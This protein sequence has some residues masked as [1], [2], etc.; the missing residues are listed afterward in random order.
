[1]ITDAGKTY[2]KGFLGGQTATIAQ[3]IALGIADSAPSATDTKMGLEIERDDI[4]LTSYD[5]VSENIVFKAAISPDFIGEIHEVG[6]YAS[7]A[8]AS[9]SDML[10]TSFDSATEDWLTN[11]ADAT[12]VETNTRSGLDSLVQ[13]PPVSTAS[14]STLSDLGIDLST[15]RG[16]DTLTFAYN[17][18]N[19]DAASIEFRFLTD[20]TNYYSFLL[21]ASTLGYHV[22]SFAKATATVTGTPDWAN[23]IEL[24]IITTADASGPAHVSF[25]AVRINSLA[26]N[27]DAVLIAREVLPE[28]FVRQAAKEQQ[29]EFR[30]V[31][32]L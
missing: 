20:A 9:D 3:S 24:D 32:N 14:T 1:M 5:F 26:T 28:P 17:V 6:L 18:G 15:Y 13:T 2:I 29:I 19:P 4:I 21:D 25:D 31:V 12:F 30:L 7:P 16:S 27:P 22:E 11:G 23:I 10:I 8:S